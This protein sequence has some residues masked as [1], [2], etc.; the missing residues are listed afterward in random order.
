M[1]EVHHCDYFHYNLLT[2]LI[3]LYSSLEAG[4]AL[5]DKLPKRLRILCFGDSLTAGYTSMGTEHYPYAV[6]LRTGLQQM[7]NTPDIDVEI[8][9]LSGDQVQG[10]YLKR[11]RAACTGNTCSNY[12]WII[13]MGGTNDLGWGQKPEAI[14]AGLGTL[15]PFCHFISRRVHFRLPL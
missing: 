13:I 10:Q 1:S 2:P 12:D 8:A 9:G 6:H 11:I 14:Y 4:M 3:S 7:L 15:S 5:S